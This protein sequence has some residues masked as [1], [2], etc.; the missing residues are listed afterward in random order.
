MSKLGTRKAVSEGDQQHN[1]CLYRHVVLSTGGTG[2]GMLSG[3]S[4]WR[5]WGN[6]GLLK[7]VA[8]ITEGSQ[9][10]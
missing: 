6:H 8:C 10:F 3:L 7:G 1:H 9:H 5:G 2:S 4:V